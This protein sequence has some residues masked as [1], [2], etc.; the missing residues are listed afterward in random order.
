M[1]KFDSSFFQIGR[2]AESVV[3]YVKSA[4]F[5]KDS[6]LKFTTFTNWLLV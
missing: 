1:D 3:V 6:V 2:F 4:R 5:N